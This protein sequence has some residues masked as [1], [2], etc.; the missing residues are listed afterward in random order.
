MK[1]I[2]TIPRNMNNCQI[3]NRYS[4]GFCH[5]YDNRQIRY[6]QEFQRLY[7]IIILKL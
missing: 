3:S 5:L 7:M 6:N 1:N 4:H 2:F